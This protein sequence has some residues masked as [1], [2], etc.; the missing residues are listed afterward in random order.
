[1]KHNPPPDS[2]S[3]LPLGGHALPLRMLSPSWI[4]IFILVAFV[5]ISATLLY[6]VGKTMFT[7]FWVE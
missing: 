1:M 3:E 7:E 5:S 2:P 6:L 4:G